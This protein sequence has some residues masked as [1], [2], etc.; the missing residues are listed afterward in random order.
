MPT[1]IIRAKKPDRVRVSYPSLLMGNLAKT[2]E[3]ST[4]MEMG[5]S[6][7]EGLFPDPVARDQHRNESAEKRLPVGRVVWDIAK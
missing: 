3:L 5:E 6:D 4:P 1:M 2:V 7:E